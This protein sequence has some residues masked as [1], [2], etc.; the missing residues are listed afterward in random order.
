M[1]LRVSLFILVAALLPA[2]LH[3]AGSKKGKAAISFHLQAD[4]GDAPKMVYPMMVNDKQL[5]FK[6]MPEFTTED[7]AA[8]KAIPSK[9]KQGV[10]DIML[11]LKPKT[12]KRLQHITNVHRGKYLAAQLNGRPGEA[13]IIDAQVNDGILMIW[14]AATDADLEILA[15]TLEGGVE[16]Q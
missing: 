9:T 1:F 2:P 12:A 5:S 7:F 16:L 14:G 6:R 10:Y 4:V 8:Y 3:A 13:V 15:E 11:Q